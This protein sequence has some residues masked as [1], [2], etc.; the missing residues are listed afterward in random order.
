MREVGLGGYEPG[1]IE[2]IHSDHVASLTTLLAGTS[3]SDQWLSR[4]EGDQLADSAVCVFPPN[5]VKYPQESSLTYLGVFE[6]RRKRL[7]IKLSPSW[8]FEQWLKRLVR[9]KKKGG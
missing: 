6:Y 3:Y 4:L 5:T 8:Y 7:H 2:A 1:C 9:G